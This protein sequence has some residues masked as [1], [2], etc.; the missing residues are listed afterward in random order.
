M[1]RGAILIGLLSIIIYFIYLFLERKS[2]K[3][4]V[5]AVIAIFVFGAYYVSE[6]MLQKSTLFRERLYATMEG[7]TSG[8]DNIYDFLWFYYLYRTTTEEKIIGMGANSTLDVYGQKAHNDWLEMVINQGLVGV[9]IYLLYWL[10]F[11]G[12]CMKKDIP[13]D[14]KYALRMLFVI[15]LM[16]TFFSMSYSD[17]LL[18]NNIVFGL[19][20][21]ACIN[22]SKSNLNILKIRKKN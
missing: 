11:L 3:I 10:A 5:L 17:Y 13:V 1:K 7:E 9:S 8:R 4:G 21:A 15:N 12:L 22:N 2:S 16:K 20:V 19:C 14:V 6:Q 18:Y